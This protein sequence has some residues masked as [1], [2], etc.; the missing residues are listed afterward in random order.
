MLSKITEYAN[1]NQTRLEWVEYFMSIA[2]LASQHRPCKR[3]NVGSV[4][5]KITA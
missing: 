5:V 4:I 3:L 1:S 2:V